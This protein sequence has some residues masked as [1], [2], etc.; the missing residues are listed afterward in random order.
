MKTEASRKPVPLDA[1][2]EGKPL[3][4]SGPHETA[5][6]VRAILDP[7]ERHMDPGNFHYLVL[8]DQTGEI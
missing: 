3:Y 5:T 8:A 1:G 2:H 7:L 6:Q 4:V